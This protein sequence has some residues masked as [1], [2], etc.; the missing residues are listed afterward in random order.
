MDRDA[1]EATLLSLVVLAAIFFLGLLPFGWGLGGSLVSAVLV[2]AVVWV[3]VRA[4]TSR[5]NSTRPR[6]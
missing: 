2:S 6:P 1:R 3:A 4:V 5:G